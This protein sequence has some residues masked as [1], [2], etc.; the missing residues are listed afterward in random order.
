[1][2]T[3]YRHLRLLRSRGEILELHTREGTVRYDGNTDVHYHF[4]CDRCGRIM[5]LDEPVDA[6]LE[7]RVAARTGL[8]VTRHSLDVSG[9]CPECLAAD[10][11]DA[12]AGSEEL[13]KHG[14]VVPPGA[15]L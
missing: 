1:M 8:M 13:Q 9:V 15:A 2:A 14:L 7:S 10:A 3:V 4:H 11:R 5:D 12:A 6:T